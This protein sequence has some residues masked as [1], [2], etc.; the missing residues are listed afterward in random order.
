V[1]QKQKGFLSPSLMIQMP[2]LLSA[3]KRKS[4]RKKESK[5][6]RKLAKKNAR[7]VSVLE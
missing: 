5:K 6:E 3:Y 2:S 4:K 1:G 7:L